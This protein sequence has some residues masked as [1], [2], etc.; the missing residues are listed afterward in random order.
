MR[1]TSLIILLLLIAGV[2]SMAQSIGGMKVSDIDVKYVEIVG[3]ANLMG[4]KVKVSID[5]GQKKK[6][7]WNE[8]DVV[9]VNADGTKMKLDSMVDALNWFDEFGYEYVNSYA[10]THGNQNVYHFLLKR[11]E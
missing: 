1:K 7:T 2:S 9:V 4:T 6:F 11:R 10:I 8:K 5:F 3:T